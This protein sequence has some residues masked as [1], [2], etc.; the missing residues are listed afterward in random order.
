[1]GNKSYLILRFCKEK[2]IYLC[3]VPGYTIISLLAMVLAAF[4]LFFIL[5]ILGRYSPLSMPY[6]RPGTDEE[7]IICNSETVDN[8]FNCVN[9]G[10]PAFFILVLLFGL[11]MPLVFP[12]QH[13]EKWL[14][15][16]FMGLIALTL[17]CSLI[18]YN[19]G[20]IGYV[21]ETNNLIAHEEHIYNE[22]AIIRNNSTYLKPCYYSERI[23]YYSADCT[24][25]G[26]MTIRLIVLF[27][28]FLLFLGALLSSCS[29]YVY[30]FCVKCKHDVKELKADMD[31][32]DV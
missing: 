32:L 11:T 24:Y 29:R 5:Y 10:L 21:F 3:R 12:P 1:M 30:S 17:I 7:I 25:V 9:S 2:L 8:C 4:I 20:Y 6:Y 22:Y 16:L 27:I 19:L 26:N 14:K 28:S 13:A 15:L 31:K 23:G 18:F